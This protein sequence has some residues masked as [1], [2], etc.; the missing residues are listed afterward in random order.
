MYYNEQKATVK[1]ECVWAV[2]EK[3]SVSEFLII[4]H[5]FITFLIFVHSHVA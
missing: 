4:R 2:M 1:C 3:G 5:D